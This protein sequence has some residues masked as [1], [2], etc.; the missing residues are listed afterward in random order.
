MNDKEIKVM[1]GFLGLTDTEKINILKE[2][3]NYQSS[4]PYTRQT[5]ETDIRY[6]SSVGPK[7]TICDCCGR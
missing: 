5:I 6:K 2:I 3:N 1:R 4:G 7:N